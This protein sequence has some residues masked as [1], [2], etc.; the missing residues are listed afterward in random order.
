MI[1][2]KLSKSNNLCAHIQDMFIDPAYI[3]MSIGNELVNCLNK[4][5]WAS[6]CYKS[7]L[8]SSS[9]NTA[10]YQNS[11]YAVKG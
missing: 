7:L 4:L 8:Q 9:K 6:G 1:E 3:Q 5:A 11:G 2:L 10:F